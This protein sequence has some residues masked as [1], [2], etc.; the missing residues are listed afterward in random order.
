MKASTQ[1]ASRA[2]QVRQRRTQ[3][4]QQRVS[5][6]SQQ[7]ARPA[8]TPPVFVRGNAAGSPVRQKT[9]TRTRRQYYYTLNAT[10]A[11]VRL[12]AFPAVRP[13]WRLL[14]GLMVIGLL[15]ALFALWSMPM[16]QLSSA[17]LVGAKRLTASD[18][19]TVLGIEGI[20]VIKATPQQMEKDL[21]AA[22]PDLSAVS[23][24]VGLPASLVVSVT[25]RQPVLAWQQNG[26]TLMDRRQRGSLPYARRRPDRQPGH[27]AGPGRPGL[28]PYPGRAVQHGCGAGL[29]GHA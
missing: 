24:R 18:V 4:S 2:D 14:S 26:Q 20:P 1:S 12:P 8:N 6:V 17:R 19:N 15:A 5:R 27:R 25:E 22:F 10:G 28:C 21:L 16:F 7:A 23:V 3:H 29:H 9:P 11:E 13:G